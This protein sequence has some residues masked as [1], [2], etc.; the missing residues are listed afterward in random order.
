MSIKP[1]RIEIL[2]AGFIHLVWLTLLA[3]FILGKSPVI[4]INFLNNDWIWNSIISLCYNHFSF[5][6]LGTLAENFVI[7]INYFRKNEG[8]RNLSRKLFKS[9]AA[10]NWG[11]KSF[12]FSSF[13]G[14]LLILLILMLSNYVDSCNVKLAI[15]VLGVLL[16]IGTFIS[17]LYW[18]HM[19][20][21][22]NQ[23]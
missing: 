5:I 2:F 12:F 1:L 14:L 21:K 4:I 9:S 3:F 20:K 23:E 8:Q 17:L 11:A 18:I 19:E 6:F 22:F 16:L 10:E 15:L 7:A 13:L